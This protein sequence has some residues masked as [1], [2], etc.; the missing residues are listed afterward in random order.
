MNQMTTIH[1]I[2]APELAAIEGGGINLG[3]ND[4]VSVSSVPVPTNGRPT[5]TVVP[6]LTLTIRF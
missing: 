1:P 6:V 5:L 4:T 2:H 3:P